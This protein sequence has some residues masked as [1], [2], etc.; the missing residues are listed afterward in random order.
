MSAEPLGLLV[1]AVPPGEAPLWVREKWLGLSLPLAQR[2]AKPVSY[3]TAGVL[4]GPKSPAALLVA[5]FTGKLAR[6]RGFRVSSLRAVEVLARSS[7]EAAAWW[8]QNA[9]RQLE[10]HRYFVFHEGTGHVISYNDRA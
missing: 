6:Q 10:P 5:L 3:L 4:S 7:P 1:T 2:N 8:R 9:P